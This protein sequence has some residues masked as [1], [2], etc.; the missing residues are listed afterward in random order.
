M[1]PKKAL[2]Q[3]FLRDPRILARIAAAVEP[4]ATDAVLEIGAGE[5]TLTA[6]LAPL[7]GRLVAIERDAEL[8]A[9]LEARA[10][11]GWAGTLPQVVRADALAVDWHA[12]MGSPYKVAGNIPYRITT[13]LLEKA[14][15]APRPTLIVFLVQRE[16]AERLSASPGTRAY[17]ALTVGIRAVAQVER[18]FGVAAGAFH[19][20]PRVDS[21]VV[22]LRPLASPLVQPDEEQPF[23]RFVTA[24]FGQRRRQLRRALRTVW[25]RDAPAIEAL[26]DTLG[27]DATRR[28]ETL[29][30][31]EFVALLRAGGEL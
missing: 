18:L 13:P 16:V 3:H 5:G 9:A 15:T 27:L 25:G 22:R 12:L 19:P 31:P 6:A 11:D 26:L 7:V 14:L 29:T 24:C 20:R 1:R 23:R 17:G 28:P 8:I 30:V 2:S 10:A 21:A 4:T